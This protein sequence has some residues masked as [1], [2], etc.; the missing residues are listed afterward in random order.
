MD[1]GTEKQKKYIN[2]AATNIAWAN[3][4]GIFSYLTYRENYSAGEL[5]QIDSIV[6]QFDSDLRKCNTE[7]RLFDI[8]IN[9]FEELIKIS[10]NLTDNFFLL[11]GCLKSPFGENEDSL[12]SRLMV[13]LEPSA[14][15]LLPPERYTKYFSV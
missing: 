7:T 10:P 3:S 4:R 8:I 5:S 9:S 14:K 6:R 12:Y 15:E 2:E 13:E 1:Q 11:I